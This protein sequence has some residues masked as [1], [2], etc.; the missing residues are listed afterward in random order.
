M[1]LKALG[2]KVL[3]ELRSTNKKKIGDK[4]I[5]LQTE[6]E[7]KKEVF[8]AGLGP[9]VS[10]EIKVGDKVLLFNNAHV[11]SPEEGSGL[12]IVAESDIWA[13]IE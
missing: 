8:V 6:T 11:V 4:E 1:K 12:G 10:G 7:P 13:I 5:I 2:N 3:L 9:D